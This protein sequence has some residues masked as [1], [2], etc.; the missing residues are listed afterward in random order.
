MPSR[1]LDIRREGHAITG[2]A[3]TLFSLLKMEMTDGKLFNTEEDRIR[4]LGH[5][6]ESVGIDAAVKLGPARLWREAIA[7][8]PN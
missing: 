7:N 4:V 5:L 6:L 1:K 8:L 2:G 3:N